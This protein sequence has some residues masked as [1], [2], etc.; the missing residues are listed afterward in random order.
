MTNLEKYKDKIVDTSSEDLNGKIAI[1]KCEDNI[2]IIPCTDC[3][4]QSCLFNGPKGCITSMIEWFVEDVNWRENLEPGTIVQVKND[5][6]DNNFIITK[7]YKKVTLW[8]LVMNHEG[9][10]NVVSST[11]IV[12]VVGFSDEV[13]KFLGEK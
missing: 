10:F 1:I 8:Y 13:A 12:K 7:K 2:D 11:D 4:C 9:D 6:L 3:K 5:Y